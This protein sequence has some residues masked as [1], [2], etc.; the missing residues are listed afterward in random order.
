MTLANLDFEAPKANPI[1]LIEHLVSAQNWPFDRSADDELNLCV[2]GKWCDYHLS[3]TWR[4]DLEALHV[5]SAFDF[6]TPKDRRGE[7]YQLIGLINERMWLGHFDLSSEDGTILY[8]HGL[9]LGGTVASAEQCDTLIQIAVE[10][11]ERYYP[12]FQFV[13][14][15]GKTAK[16][17]MDASMFDCHGEA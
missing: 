9:L 1:D 5:A 17:A 3:F 8:R 11:A 2:A 15:A 4:D 13:M 10:S 7:L 14:W 16:E 12:A 6:K